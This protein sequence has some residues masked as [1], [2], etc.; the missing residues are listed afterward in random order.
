MLFSQIKN[1]KERRRDFY[2]MAVRDYI[3]DSLNGVRKET[4]DEVI[5]RSENMGLAF[6]NLKKE[7]DK[8]YREHQKAKVNMAIYTAQID[9][10]K[11]ENEILKSTLASK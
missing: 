4:F 10:L 11:R 7:Y 6:E 8:L 1:K 9:S 3:L 2:I 5:K